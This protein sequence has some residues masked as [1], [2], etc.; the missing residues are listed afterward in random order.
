[1]GSVAKTGKEALSLCYSIEQWVDIHPVTKLK[2]KKEDLNG[3]SE[4]SYIAISS[5][6]FK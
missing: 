6:D 2:Y 3:Q 1:M 4:F 5:I